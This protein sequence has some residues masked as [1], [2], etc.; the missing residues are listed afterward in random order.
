VSPFLK[1]DGN[2]KDDDTEG[3]WRL[4]LWYNILKKDKVMGVSILK[5]KVHRGSES[6]LFSRSTN[7]FTLIELLVV[8][9]IIAVL[10]AMLLPA[11][12]KA[13]QTAYD[14]GCMSNLKQWGLAFAMYSNDN[15]EQ[16]PMAYSYNVND[17]VWYHE[18][19]MGRYIALAG[20]QY[21]HPDIWGRKEICNGVAVC[22]AHV[23]AKMG[24]YFENGIPY[25]RSY[26][27]NYNI[28]YMSGSYQ[29]NYR[30]FASK[31]RLAVLGDGSY[32]KPEWA[33]KNWFVPGWVSYFAADP[34]D[35]EFERHSGRATL[36]LADWHV[37]ALRFSD[38]PRL[39]VTGSWWAQ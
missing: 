26:A 2:E 5:H 20:G 7:G 33:T 4:V 9:A 10:I 27:Y 25:G 6:K 24:G 22:P 37:A 8:V 36:L 21:S 38:S 14:A 15:Y 32:I 39:F 13:R 35:F 30:T 19:T 1:G 31:E 23:E 11:M 3:D 29:F 34:G 17:P 18:A 16:M 28:P 12:K